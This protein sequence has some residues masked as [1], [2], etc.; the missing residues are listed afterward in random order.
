MVSTEVVDDAGDTDLKLADSPGK[1]PRLVIEYVPVEGDS[2][3]ASLEDVE[4]CT[5]NAPDAIGSSGE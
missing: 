3:S 4:V 2:L 5:G 1:T